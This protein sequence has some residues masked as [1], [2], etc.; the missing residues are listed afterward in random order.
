MQ[1][2]DALVVMKTGRH[3]PKVRRALER[4]AG[5]RMRG[6]RARHHAGQRVMRLAETE[7]GEC[8]YSQPFWSTVRAAVR[9]WRNDRLAGDRRPRP[10]DQAL[11]TSEVTAALRLRPTSSAIFPM[12]RGWRRA[13]A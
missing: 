12:S 13:K 6:C 4:A 3:L 7:I 9:S 11:V 10:G 2:A 8:P 5:L 1:S